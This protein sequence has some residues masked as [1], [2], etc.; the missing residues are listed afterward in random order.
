MQYNR[1]TDGT[2]TNLKN[3]H[4]DTG[5]GLERLVS[6]LQNCTNYQIDL[7]KEI[8]NIIQKETKAVLYED[9]YGSKIKTILILLI[10]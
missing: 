8:I 5:M 1:D 10:V 2:I 7:F 9:K 4:I 6:I 3:K